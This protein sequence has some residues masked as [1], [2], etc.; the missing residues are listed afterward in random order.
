MFQS[1]AV[2][3]YI[4]VRSRS[5]KKALANML[6]GLANAKGGFRAIAGQTDARYQSGFPFR[7]RFYSAARRRE[8]ERE[9]AR[10]FGTNV[11]VRR[12]RMK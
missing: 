9:A 8:F 6:R 3:V 5:R 7:F 1:F 11:E 2:N 12:I 4:R 10:T